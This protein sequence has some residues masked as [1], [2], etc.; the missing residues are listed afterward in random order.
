[1][2]PKVSAQPANVLNLTAIIE[3]K[4]DAVPKRSFGLAGFHRPGFRRGM[5]NL[6]QERIS[7]GMRFL[8]YR[9][10]LTVYH[11]GALKRNVVVILGPRHGGA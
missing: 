8:E 7:E 4:V 9:L 5:Q 6:N 3:K 11:T 10:A 1:M 2:K